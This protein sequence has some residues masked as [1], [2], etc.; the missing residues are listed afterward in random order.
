MERVL[1]V[2]KREKLW[3]FMMFVKVLNLMKI[4]LIY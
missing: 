4:N 2:F 3:G 1:V